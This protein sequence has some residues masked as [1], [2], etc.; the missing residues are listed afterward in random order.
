MGNLIKTLKHFENDT[1]V[2]IFA[3]FLFEMSS[4]YFVM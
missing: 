1:I 4:D 3:G 2:L